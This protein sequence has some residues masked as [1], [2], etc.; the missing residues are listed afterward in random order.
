MNKKLYAT[1]TILMVAMLTASPVLAGGAI[2]LSGSF[3]MSSLW[4]KG[5]MTGLGG[6]REGVTLYLEASGNPEVI[7]TNYGGNE[8]PGQNPPKVTA[9]GMLLIP[10]SEIDK[11]GKA[12]VFVETDDPDLTG[13]AKE[14]GCP[15]NNWSAEIVFIDWTDAKIFVYDAINGALLLEQYY[16]CETT[17]YPDNTG[18]V[19]CTLYNEV[20]YH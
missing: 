8:A 16:T 13:K 7:C 9:S 4:F 6:Y 11:K 10:K 3:G 15:N 20:S 19:S 17:R 12:Y 14:F 18:D 2:K 5:T 1:L